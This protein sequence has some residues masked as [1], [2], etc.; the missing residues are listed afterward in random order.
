M[1]TINA[2]TWQRLHRWASNPSYQ[3][4]F[5]LIGAF[6]TYAP[7]YCR[8]PSN[9]EN[10]E[11][12]NSLKSS[13]FRESSFAILGLTLVYLLDSVVD[14]FSSW[15]SNIRHKNPET[16]GKHMMAV[17]T[18]YERFV[19][20]IGVLLVPVIALLPTSSPRLALIYSCACRSQILVLGGYVIVAS[21]IRFPTYFPLVTRWIPI[22]ACWIPSVVS[23]WVFNISREV[24]PLRDALYYTEFAGVAVYF[25]CALRWLFLDFLAKFVVPQVRQW[26]SEWWDSDEDESTGVAM[27][28][29][30]KHAQGVAYFPA[31]SV[32]ISLMWMI[33]TA[34]IFSFTAN[35]YDLAGRDLLLLNIPILLYQVSRG[36][37]L[38]AALIGFALSSCRFISPYPHPRV[39]ARSP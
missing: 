32:L 17:I 18:E 28:E 3:L 22:L 19:F 4:T 12:H 20:C 8:V 37:G 15:S 16:N 26:W 30:A 11:L 35:L 9:M 2:E 25:V 1:A 34:A 24:T 27:T 21:S 36:D 31:A 23:P 14:L 7:I 5:I 39:P 6:I 13:Q 33:F 38:S 10:S 29:R